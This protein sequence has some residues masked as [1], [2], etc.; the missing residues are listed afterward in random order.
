MILE[1]IHDFGKNSRFW[2]KF[3]I[4]EKIKLGKI[5]EKIQDFGKSHD[6]GKNS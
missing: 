1:K 6:F 4:L 2:K 3:A 5:L